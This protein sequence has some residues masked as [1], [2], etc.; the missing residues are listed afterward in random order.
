KTT[1]LA[2]LRA[3]LF[4]LPDARRAE[5]RYAPPPGA[6][7]GGRLD[8][9]M[10]DGRRF[11]IERHVTWAAK[12]GQVTVTSLDGAGPAVL[13]DLLPGATDDLFCNAFAFG[14]KELASLVGP[15]QTRLHAAAAGSGAL[16]VFEAQTRLHEQAA[17]LFSPGGRNPVINGLLSQYRAAEDELRAARTAAQE[18]PRHQRTK[19]E[20]TAGLRGVE[21]EL[22]AAR[23]RE[24][25]LDTLSRALPICDQLW[26][27]RAEL[28]A[29][30]LAAQVPEGGV[31]RLERMLADLKNARDRRT[32]AQEALARQRA[33][34]DA[35]EVDGAVLAL[36]A[37]IGECQSRVGQVR[38]AER[39]LPK[40]RAEE[41]QKAQEVAEGLRRLGEGWTEERAVAFDDSLPVEQ[42]IAAAE[43]R[44]QVLERARH[45]HETGKRSADARA[46]EERDQRVQARRDLDA[47]W[48][49]PPGDHA[50]IDDELKRTAGARSLAA[51]LGRDDR[52]EAK[53][54]ARRAADADLARIRA[55][56]PR[57]PAPPAALW[58]V[59]ALSAVAL[60]AMVALRQGTAAIAATAVVAVGAVLAALLARRA[61]SAPAIEAHAAQVSAAEK[62]LRQAEGDLKEVED[63][64]ERQRAELAP[65]LEA[66]GLPP[67]AC[68]ADLEARERALEEERD[69]ARKRDDEVR[70]LRD[71]EQ[72]EERAT[73]AA[74]QAAAALAAAEADVQTGSADWERWLA[75][76]SLPRGLQPAGAR[77]FIGLVRAVRERVRER[78]ALRQRID[79]MERCIADFRKGVEGIDGTVA[80]DA[81]VEALVAACE[82]ARRRLEAADQAA[83]RR[84]ELLRALPGL[85]AALAHWSG[86]EREA[87]AALRALLEEAGVETEEA[88]R[89]RA[90]LAGIRC[91][92]EARV[93]QL[94]GQ[95]GAV[96]GPA[97]ERERLEAEVAE[98]DAGAL[99]M[100]IERLRAGIAE[101]EAEQRRIAGE[102]GEVGKTLRDLLQSERIEELG[103]KRAGLAAQIAHEADAWA[104]LKVCAW[105]LGQARER[106]ERD[107][108]PE[109]MRR[110]GEYVRA[111]TGGAYEGLVASHTEKDAIEV[112]APDGLRKEQPR[113]N[114]GLLEQIYLCLRLGFIGEYVRG[115][116]PLPVV[117]DDILANSDPDHARRAAELI[118]RFAS[119]YQVL[120]L[121]CH[122]ETAGLLAGAVPGLHRLRLRGG[123]G[124]PIAISAP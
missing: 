61:A 85:E 12:R 52:R 73:R 46:A 110:A 5:N 116:E 20:L 9:L 92:A 107:R 65:L 113:W 43:T 22:S 3:V 4:G 35:I 74:D 79:A 2:F 41:R 115:A 108:Q 32:D 37:G 123:K 78:D 82:Q 51:D 75:S 83:A 80:T 94:E 31:E 8:V 17:K 40:R 87:D 23:A 28:E 60:V 72:A 19:E 100:E 36:R 63:E 21:D 71:L 33:D 56:G 68:A 6:R 48:P 88:F 95:L 26:Q 101:R 18:A 13:A 45:E 16:G 11:R 29:L 105:L 14:L 106:F 42:A 86:K 119:E 76:R 27:A 25:R 53:E 50:T 49:Q 34:A 1:L 122:P 77:E 120:Y 70:R 99:R 55:E 67:D 15:V 84:D 98:W 64:R 54:Q 58:A 7:H 91:D 103:Q 96:A 102:L 57:V 47:R 66:L 89:E 97:G 112:V 124:A 118:A 24:R 69:L 114:Q 62:T 10:R 104:E 121:T 90:R 38:D 59:A 93:R 117:M 39:D 81:P 111:V 30:P 44:W 109:V